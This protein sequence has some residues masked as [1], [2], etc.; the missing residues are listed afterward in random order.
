VSGFV[1]WY[2]LRTNGSPSVA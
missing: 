1:A 2:H